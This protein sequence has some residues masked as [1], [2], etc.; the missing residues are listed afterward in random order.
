MRT[1]GFNILFLHIA[2]KCQE[3]L[4]GETGLV[5]LRTTFVNVLNIFPLL[6]ARQEVLELRKIQPSIVT[7]I[8]L[9]ELRPKHVLGAIDVQAAADTLDGSEVK[10]LRLAWTKALGEQSRHLTLPMGLEDS[11]ALG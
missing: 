2:Q 6:Q 10:I 3:F 11:V 1:I 5:I 4:L 7:S 8:S 9:G